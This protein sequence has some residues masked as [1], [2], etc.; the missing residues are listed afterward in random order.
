MDSK[1]SMI[2]FFE[3]SKKQKNFE[4]P[5]DVNDQ[6]IGILKKFNDPKLIEMINWIRTSKTYGDFNHSKVE[7]DLP[8]LTATGKAVKGV[9]KEIKLIKYFGDNN[10]FMQSIK[11]RL[12]NFKNSKGAK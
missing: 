11:N 4:L 9:I 3:N 5:K 1:Y 10:W 6:I 8:I 2:D 12:V 7:N